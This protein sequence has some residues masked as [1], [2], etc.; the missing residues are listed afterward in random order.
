[1]L[2]TGLLPTAPA[3]AEIL[4]NLTGGNHR[5]YKSSRWGKAK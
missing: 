5:F 2:E 3:L 1:M 4:R